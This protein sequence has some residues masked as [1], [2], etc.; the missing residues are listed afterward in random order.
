VKTVT[1][2]LG[3]I[4]PS[5]LDSLIDSIVKKD[6]NSVL[7][8]ISR[9]DEFEAEMVID[10]LML[11]LKDILLNSS[12]KIDVATIDRFFR[13]LADGKSLLAIGSSGEFV[14][15][16]TLLKMLDSLKETQ[17][18]VVEREPAT[19]IKTEIESKKREE[20]PKEVKTKIEEKPIEPKKEVIEEVDKGAEKFKRLIEKIYDRNYDLG[21]CF[22]KN[23]EYL[24]YRENLLTWKSRAKGEERRLLVFRWGMI[25][26]F[27]QEVFGINIKIKNI[28]EERP[29]K[30][31]EIKKESPPPK[32]QEV[33][34]EPKE[35]KKISS[36][37]DTEMVKKAIELLDPKRVTIK[38]EIG[39][40]S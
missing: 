21:S 10:E 39:E 28:E 16:L 35:E 2:M 14:L 18:R 32:V 13:V 9:A 4:E 12:R 38:G 20:E 7:E 3:I 37:K 30:E 1:D 23:I 15:S 31:E 6:E 33:K 34:R 8:F 40:N 27:T 25:K 17:I 36:I 11:Y 24:S 22:E 26:M 5:I 19:T 29:K